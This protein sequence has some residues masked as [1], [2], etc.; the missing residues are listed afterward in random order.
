MAL[1]WN[2]KK[3]ITVYRIHISLSLYIYI[4]ICVHIY[5]Y[6]SV[7][8]AVSNE[9]GEPRRF[10]LIRFPFAHCANGSL[11]FVC[12]RR[13][14]RKLSV[15]KRLNGLAHLWFKLNAV[16]FLPQEPQNQCWTDSPR[17]PVSFLFW[18]SF[19]FFLFPYHSWPE[20]IFFVLRFFYV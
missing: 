10:S 12:L 1:C 6:I 2:S 3:S 7:Y 16:P 20:L 9:K 15:C 19:P 8:A 13:N 4:Y 14:K 17:W 5:I 11:L 18:W